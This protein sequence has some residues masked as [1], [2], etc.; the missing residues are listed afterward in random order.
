MSCAICWSE[1]DN[2]SLIYESNCKP[3][4]HKF[5]IECIQLAYSLTKQKECPYCRQ[6]LNI[7]N[8]NKLYPKCKYILT[9]GQ[10]KGKRCSNYAKNENGL[11]NIHKSKINN[12]ITPLPNGE[13]V[14]PATVVQ[15]VPVDGITPEEITILPVIG[16]L[17]ESATVEEPVAVGGKATPEEITEDDSL[18]LIKCISICKSTQKQ[19]KNKKKIGNYCGIHI[20]IYT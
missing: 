20:K 7:S 16:E 4:S 5:H 19:C 14:E 2:E 6:N 3:V 17:P 9:K 18:N 13:A 8:Y 11:C 15:H 1:F 12:E 10:N